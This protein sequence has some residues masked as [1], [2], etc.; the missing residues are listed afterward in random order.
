MTS[1]RAPLL[2]L[3]M[4]AAIGGA[5]RAQEVPS[6]RPGLDTL[7]PGPKLPTPES[8]EGQAVTSGGN[9]TNAAN[10]DLAFG[11][12]QRG[13]YE[14]ALKEALKRVAA[15]KHDAAAMTLIGHLYE[16][17]YGVKQDY[18]TSAQWYAAAAAEG[19]VQAIF[20]LAT[21][22]LQGRGVKKDVAGAIQ[23][24][25]QAAAKNDPLSLYNLGMLELQNQTGT[26]DFKKAADYFSRAAEL[27]LADA[28]YALALLYRNGRGVTR[29]DKV[30]ALWMDRAA[31]GNNVPAEV[32]YAIMLFN[33]AGID[34]DE[35]AAAKLFLKAASANNPI[36]QDRI[37]RLLVTGRG[38]KP[39]LIEAMKWHILAKSAGEK[40]PWLDQFLNKLT[41]EQKKEVNAA[42]QQYVGF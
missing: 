15:N 27:G 31:K 39:D 32:E 42:V 4:V 2:A 17:G 6:R 38:I 22:K 40:D 10:T 14:T 18:A 36:A 28:A 35:S 13:F 11:A 19:N 25:Q 12:Y 29:D 8:P 3:C 7:T 26:P 21:D 24:F 41:P 16:Q 23:L 5:A 33:G 9:P 20:S 34:K 1:V 37:A 30:A